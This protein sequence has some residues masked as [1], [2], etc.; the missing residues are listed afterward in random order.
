[1]KRKIA[2]TSALMF[3]V[4]VMALMR[5]D[6]STRAQNQ[7]R[8]VYDTGLVTLGPGQT[9][10]VSFSANGDSGQ[11]LVSL[12]SYVSGTCSPDNICRH[13][14]ASETS[15]GPVSLMNHEAVTIDVP[16]APGASGV[17]VMTR[18]NIKN[19]TVTV[20][21]LDALGNIVSYCDKSSPLF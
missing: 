3:T 17:R 10:K 6:S 1:L 21:I 13:N 8:F 20:S 11:L 19:V 16:M 4:A 15:H 7:N 12:G 5:S 14:L 9:M 18:T 2:L